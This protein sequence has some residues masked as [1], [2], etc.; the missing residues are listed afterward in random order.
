[1]RKLA[2]VCVFGIVFLVVLLLGHRAS[3]SDIEMAHIAADAQVAE[4]PPPASTLDADARRV[5]APAH[6][7]DAVVRSAAEHEIVVEGV[8]RAARTRV[9]VRVVD[10]QA[11][12]VAN[13]TV[14][15]AT[16]I[17]A[18]HAVDGASLVGATDLPHFTFSG[19]TDALGTVEFDRVQSAAW[20]FVLA[21]RRAPW[22]P[23]DESAV[24]PIARR[25]VVPEGVREFEVVLTAPR[26]LYIRGRVEVNGGPLFPPDA[27]EHATPNVILL[28]ARADGSGLTGQPA[29]DGTF[30][31]GPLT[32]DEFEITSVGRYAPIEPVRARP[33]GA[34]LVLRVEL[35]GS[36]A[37]RAMDPATHAG[38][39]CEFALTRAG[40]DVLATYGSGGA[41][42]EF[43]ISGL[44]PGA[45]TVAV[46][47]T[48]GRFGSASGVRVTPNAETSGVEL[49]LTPASECAHV[50]VSARDG[51]D[52]QVW[53]AAACRVVAYV[54][55][56][57]TRTLAVPAGASELRF[58][59]G[60]RVLERHVLTL[61]AGETA[62]VH[63]P[64]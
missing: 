50:D 45:Y 33:G 6:V 63:F 64:R 36:L 34:P 52:V 21:P 28:A 48:D 7:A 20:W 19:R 59:S 43:A 10:D 41:D 51:V 60:L 13:Q 24:A 26:G 18:G 62:V 16:E 58:M 4:A 27:D 12:P 1:M 39:A 56:G 44:A 29:L 55:T 11:A 53:Q 32:D 14:G 9:L 23:V 54:R 31:I 2:V 22:D 30:A 38:V 37:G 17:G 5:A 35:G 25:V 61:A 47:T 8:E 40:A 46:W 3:L 49:A 57:S 42:G 15:L